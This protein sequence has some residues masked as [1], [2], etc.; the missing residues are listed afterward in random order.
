MR[1]RGVTETGPPVFGAE[2]DPALLMIEARRLQAEVIARGF[3]ALWGALGRWLGPALRRVVD[4][5]ARRSRRAHAVAHLRGLDN[6]LLADIGLPR[7]DI[8]LAVDGL[9]ADRRG[10]RPAA[11]AW[12]RHRLAAGDPRPAPANANRAPGAAA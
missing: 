3:T 5:P 12:D 10:P 7:G 1:T 4:L 2:M 6:R 8:E 9:L 11:P